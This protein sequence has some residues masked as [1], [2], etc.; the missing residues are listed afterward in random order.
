[1]TDSPLTQAVDGAYDLSAVLTVCQAA[2]EAADQ[3]SDPMDIHGITAAVVR[4]LR[5]VAIPMAG[6]AIDAL[7]LEE[8]KTKGVGEL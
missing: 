8:R 4:T 2:L 6:N 7:E 3:Y 1:M 5:D